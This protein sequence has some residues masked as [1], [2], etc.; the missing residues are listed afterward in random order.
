MPISCNHSGSKG[1]CAQYVSEV[2]LFMLNMFGVCLYIIWRILVESNWT[3][4]TMK[5]SFPCVTLYLR[6][7]NFGEFYVTEL[8]VNS[9]P[10]VIYGISDLN[11]SHESLIHLICDISPSQEWLKGFSFILRLF[12]TRRAFLI[13][14]SSLLDSLVPRPLPIFQCC[15]HH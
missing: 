14:Q 11:Q 10:W 9:F 3:L 2:Y 7:Y 4:F 8:R 6:C 12:Q 1:F 15:V 5:G 13:S